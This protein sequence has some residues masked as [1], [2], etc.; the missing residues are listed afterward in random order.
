MSRQTAKK[1]VKLQ[2]L[3]TFIRNFA[4]NQLRSPTTRAQKA[5][6]LFNVLPPTR[7][8]RV[9]QTRNFVLIKMFLTFKTRFLDPIPKLLVVVR[10]LSP[11]SKGFLTLCNQWFVA[12]QDFT[13]PGWKK[14]CQQPSSENCVGYETSPAP[15]RCLK[16]MTSDEL[17]SI[18]QSP[19][20]F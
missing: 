17:L 12:C 7:D 11:F 4:A 16:L 5:T 14:C 9:L 8:T 18:P 19:V 3:C 6:Q 2:C 15:P 1:F 20:I 10:R 13:F